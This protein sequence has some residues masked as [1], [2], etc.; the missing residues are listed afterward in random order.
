MTCT[1]TCLSICVSS[2]LHEFCLLKSR[3][4]LWPIDWHKLIL[5]S[6]YDSS[7][8]TVLTSGSNDCYFE[9]F[10][11]REVYIQYGLRHVEI[12][13]RLCVCSINMTR[14]PHWCEG[15]FLLVHTYTVVSTR[16]V[17]PWLLWIMQIHGWWWV[18]SI[19]RCP[20]CKTQDQGPPLARDVFSLWYISQ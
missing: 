20:G 17:S 9:G 8:D 5:L 6:S 13:E 18:C 7:S 12:H 16:H 19:I 1:Y 2:I 4:R 14:N 10:R 3:H 15:Y 11:C